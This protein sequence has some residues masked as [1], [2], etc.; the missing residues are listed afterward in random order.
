MIVTGAV[1]A[2]AVLASSSLSLYG[3]QHNYTTCNTYKDPHHYRSDQP[4]AFSGSVLEQA[5]HVHTCYSVGVSSRAR[6]SHASPCI[7]KDIRELPAE[8][9]CLEHTAR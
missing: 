4:S 3:G 9:N 8:R 6:E 1:L 5:G 2:I 7:I